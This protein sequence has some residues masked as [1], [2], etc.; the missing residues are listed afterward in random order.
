MLEHKTLAQD[1][2]PIKE[3]NTSYNHNA[4]EIMKYNGTFHFVIRIKFFNLPWYY[5]NL[6]MNKCGMWTSVVN[7]T[8]N[9][10]SFH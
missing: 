7:T 1:N 8:S 2:T 5:G 6:S 9:R 10:M 3:G 4:R